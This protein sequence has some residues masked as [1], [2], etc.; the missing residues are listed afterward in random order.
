MADTAPMPQIYMT[1]SNAK[2]TLATKIA[3]GGEGEIWQTT[4]PDIVAKLFHKPSD[5]KHEKLRAM[6]QRPPKDPLLSQKYVS[7]AWPQDVLLTTTGEFVGYIMPRVSGALTLTNVYNPKLRQKMAAGFNWYYLHTTARN[8]ALIMAAIHN[9]GYVVGD[10]KTENIL[11]NEKALVSFTDTD[12]YQVKTN[13]DVYPCEVGSEGFTPPELIDKNLTQATRTE[14][15]DRF[16]LGVLIYMLIFGH[17]PFTGQWREDQEPLPKD[18]AIA[19]CIWPYGPGGMVQLSPLSLSLDAVSG[20]IKE[21]FLKT[22]N[23]GHD[24]PDQRVSAKEWVDILSKAIQQLQL[25]A[26]N[27]NHYYHGQHSKCLWCGRAAKFG[28]DIFPKMDGNNRLEIVSAFSQAVKTNDKRQMVMLWDTHAFLQ[29]EPRL[30]PLAPDI[31]TNR[32]NLADLDTLKQMCLEGALDVDILAFCAAHPALETLANL[33]NEKVGDQTLHAYFQQLMR[34]Q[35][36]LGNLKRYVQRVD[37]KGAGRRIDQ[38]SKIVELAE[39]YLKAARNKR[40]A[41]PERLLKRYDKAQERVAAYQE[42][43]DQAAAQDD[44]DFLKLWRRVM[45]VLKGFD[46]PPAL[47]NRADLT[48]DYYSTYQSFRDLLRVKHVEDGALIDLWEAN[49]SFQASHFVDLKKAGQPSIRERVA[50]AY[51]RLRMLKN[52]EKMALSGNAKAFLD[53]WGE[54]PFQDE[55]PF[56]KWQKHANVLLLKNEGWYRFKRALLEDQHDLFCDLWDESFTPFAVAEGFVDRI[57]SG[58]KKEL[59]ILSAFEGE[60][61]PHVAGHR[62][63]WRILAP[64]PALNWGNG[65][66][67]LAD[68]IVICSAPHQ[69]PASSDADPAPLKQR[70]LRRVRD[71]AAID[72]LMPRMSQKAY[73][74]IWPAIR[75]C[76]EIIAVGTPL[77]LRSGEN[78]NRI[79]YEVSHKKG[80][81]QGPH[82]A[83]QVKMMCKQDIPLP[84]MDVIALS[85]RIPI[86]GDPEGMRYGGLNATTLQTG[87]TLFTI[88]LEA[89]L[90]TVDFVRLYPQD[91]ALLDSFTLICDSGQD[92][93]C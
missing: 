62:D 46:I 87:Q 12:S 6:I 44:M 24:A 36:L 72:T 86:Y 56:E 34:K 91:P 2:V 48:E 57:L 84:P 18:Q 74:S 71:A 15:Q 5:L 73:F 50:T 90:D 45:K 11:V 70:I 80:S 10:I 35:K 29:K 26:V 8:I 89:P 69:Y 31:E 7:I 51:E 66:G 75:V 43:M 60:G 27:N 78:E 16:G 61:Q 20:E 22:F 28:K 92:K 54:T 85:H 67:V 30:Q 13:R 52:L 81:K 64:W 40:R 17:H 59:T 33:P 68:Y 14:A 77:M 19:R 38:E 3:A 65:K 1:P 23:A 93:V 82:G 53:L 25:C 83:L 47:V 9:R 76:G 79:V 4:Q 88:P 39:Q 21:A 55:V 32:R 63:Y 41:L 37:E 58:F 49:Q 42:L